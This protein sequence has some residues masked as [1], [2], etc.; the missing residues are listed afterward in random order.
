M[1]STINKW[2]VDEYTSLVKEKE[3]LVLL[4]MQ[5]LTV[6]QVQNLRGE[7]RQSG[8][9]LLFGKKR[10]VRV[11]LNAAG[12]EFDDTAWGAGNCALLVGDAE[13]T[14][15]AT[16]AVENAC[17]QVDKKAERPVHYRAALLDGALMGAAEAATIAAMPD[18]QTLRAMMCGAIMGP[19]RQLATIL[20]EV[21]AS[22]ARVIKARSEQEDAA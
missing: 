19:G 2:I 13:A 10:L 20:N 15:V 12:I 1:V 7:I 18:R 17:K 22:T 9:E 5:G 6:E 3:G 21:G 16:K 14:I 4:D 11:A 8:A